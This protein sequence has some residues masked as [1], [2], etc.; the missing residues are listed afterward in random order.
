MVCAPLARGYG[1]SRTKGLDAGED[2][3]ASEAPSGDIEASGAVAGETIPMRQPAKAPFHHLAP[4]DDDKA[5][6]RRI[7]LGD[8][9]AH[10][11]QVRP[12]PAALGGEGAVIDRFPQAGPHCLAAV[13]R[14]KGVAVLHRGRH[15]GDREP[16]PGGVHQGHAFATP[17][18]LAGIVPAWPAH[19]DSLDRLR[20]DDAQARR[21]APAHQATAQAGDRLHQ[22]IK[23]PASSQRRNQP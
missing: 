14:R 2:G 1:H 10:A 16:M 18:P 21:R 8:A 7:A 15:H 4:R 22:G 19:A 13:Q 5:L 6:G 3:D 23:T 20:I 9:M 11:M 12:R 17:H